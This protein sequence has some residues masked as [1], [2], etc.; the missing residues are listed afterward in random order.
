M[1]AEPKSHW[2]VHENAGN[3]GNIVAAQVLSGQ[4]LGNIRGNNYPLWGNI[5]CVCEKKSSESP[6]PNQ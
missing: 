6:L 3:M 1:R 2:C 4:H 5:S